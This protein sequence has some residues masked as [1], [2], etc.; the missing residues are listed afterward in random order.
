MPQS[1]K[2]TPKRVS[3]SRLR[4]ASAS[5][6]SDGSAS[7]IASISQP[8]TS[9][10]QPGPRAASRCARRTVTPQM[11]SS[12]GS[13]PPPALGAKLPGTAVSVRVV[14]LLA[15]EAE[16]RAAHA[17]LAVL[18]PDLVDDA[19]FEQLAQRQRARRRVRIGKPVEL[20]ERRREQRQHVELA[21]R[22]GRQ[23]RAGRVGPPGRR[24][25][26]GEVHDLGDLVADEGRGG[27]VGVGVVARA[28]R[29]GGDLPL[30][31]SRARRRRSGR[32]GS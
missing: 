11:M 30:A 1:R 15:L 24:R 20:G 17:R 9:R 31:R 18:D 14:A 28:L 8:R 22:R 19:A 32:S 5:A 13:R 12:S 16:R 6:R 25:R 2:G 21:R 23:P 29:H 10:S 27:R 7:H 4:N 3:K 26:V